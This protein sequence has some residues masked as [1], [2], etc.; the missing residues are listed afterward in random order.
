MGLFSKKLGG[1]LQRILNLFWPFK[2]YIKTMQHLS[3]IFSEYPLRPLR[4]VQ[5]FKAFEALALTC[6]DI[7]TSLYSGLLPLYP[8]ASTQSLLMTLFIFLM[9]RAMYEP[10]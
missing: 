1:S 8:S 6:S 4:Q 2:T 5:P 3:T 10:R 7:V 9:M